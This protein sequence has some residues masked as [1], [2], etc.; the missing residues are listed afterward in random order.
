M[1]KKLLILSTLLCLSGCQI[2]IISNSNS[3][4]SS[5][6]ITISDDNSSSSSSS[7]SSSNS[8]IVSSSSSN[9]SSSSSNSS[10]T[11]IE[12]TLT[13]TPSNFNT[14]NELVLDGVV[15]NTDHPEEF[16][17]NSNAVMKSNKISNL[18]S[19]KFGSFI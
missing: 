17:F 12:K 13:I 14:I 3:S 5:S 16:T 4:N 7:S 18:K 6:S 8:S 9:S 11:Y 1:K 15:E 19:I 2:T 10:I